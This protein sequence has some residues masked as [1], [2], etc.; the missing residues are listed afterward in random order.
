MAKDRP[1]EKAASEVRAPAA[2]SQ[3]SRWARLAAPSA[4][5]ARWIYQ[6]RLRLGASIAALAAAIIG[7]VLVLA[8]VFRGPDASDREELLT[9]A[10]KQL[11]TGDRQAA[12]NLAAKLGGTKSLSYAES[13][14]PLFIQGATTYAEAQEQTDPTKRR[15]LFLVAARY[16]EEARGRGWPAGRESEGLM[17][18]GQAL[19]ASGRFAESLPILREA[20][21]ADPKSAARIHWLLTDSHL[22]QSPPRLEAA[23]EHVHAYLALP[24]LS[25]YDRHAG[26]LL[27]SRI[28]LDQRQFEPAYAS[29]GQIPGSASLHP[30]SVVLQGRI[31]LAAQ[32]Q[33]KP[34]AAEAATPAALI[35]RLRQ[36]ATKA[37]PSAEV[38]PQIQLLIGMCYEALPDPKAAAG[39]YDRVRRGH[40]GRPEG[41]AASVLQA[42]LLVATNPVEAVALYRKSLEMAGPPDTYANPW[43]PI[44]EW[45]GRVERAIEQLTAAG[46]H[47]EALALAQAMPPFL[48]LASSLLARGRI[49]RAW[50]EHLAERSSRERPEQSAVTQAEARQH[51]REAGAAGRQLAEAR[52]ATHYYLNDL[53]Q[54]AGDYLRGQG[55]DQAAAAYRDL[56]KQD[57]RQ[58]EPEALVGLGEALLALGQ[59]AESMVAL[60]KCIETYPKH[61]STYRARWL[62]SLAL[63]EQGKLTDAADMLIDNL[64]RH[65]LAPQSS[66]W[67]DSLFSYGLLKY[68]QALED[69]TQSRLAGIDRDE[70][71]VPRE[72]LARLEQ[73]HA[74]FQEAVRSLKE[75]VQRYP[76]APLAATARYCVAES[77]RHG[78]KWPRKRLANVTIETTRVALNRQ[79]QEEL[80]A[81]L[82]QYNAL[83]AELS[84][85]QVASQ[86]PLEMALLRN[87]Y[88]GRGDA[89]FDLGRF[90]EAAQA[91]SAATNRYQHEPE[92]LEAYVQ[93]ASCYRRLNRPAEARSTLEQAR[94]VLQRMRP[95]ADFTR[96]TRYDRQQWADLLTWLRTL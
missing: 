95:D 80:L 38:F 37:D 91:Y 15:L 73:S 47:S 57:P 12:R 17:L 50:A 81:A 53:A 8:L 33:G 21:V 49:Q 9:E 74:A 58:G 24:K 43:L 10:L 64:Y 96:T 44:G 54:A 36:L 14:G 13:G 20:L 39:Q 1:K 2:E 41:L 83:I 87:C 11:D 16:L 78:A 34:L 4:A 18:L 29:A 67:R 59:P 76:T 84:S 56:L 52:V 66:E 88:F 6:S 22:H 32:R 28:L 63:Q 70:T 7:G 35:D 3:P 26:W 30:D 71:D 23:L 31:A 82:D 42:G 48:P 86:S 77:Y 62:A 79:V 85:G 72:A 45:S 75:A 55:Y 68:R 40:F 51:W 46:R 94:V 60:T 89:L 65:S 25:A 93:I 90:E 5:A 61:P 27:Q 69:E 92:S 19:H